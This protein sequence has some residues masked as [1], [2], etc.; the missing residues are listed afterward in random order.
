M[1]ELN[2]L[3][4]YKNIKIYQN[5]EYF[6]FILSNYRFSLLSQRR[7]ILNAAKN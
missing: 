3:L 1:K 2:Y 6:K 7:M 5:K 4:G